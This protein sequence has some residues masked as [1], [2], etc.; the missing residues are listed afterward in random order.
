MCGLIKNY[1]IKSHFP[2]IPTFQ[3]KMKLSSIVLLATLPAT[4]HALAQPA[5]GRRAFL[6][7]AA[8]NTA[9]IT[10]AAVTSSPAFAADSYS[11]DTGDV[12][13]PKKEK[14]AKSGNGGAVVGGA[15]GASVALSLPFFLPNLMRLAGINNAKNPTKK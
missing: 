2:T 5:T 9:A 12:V 1:D 3:N 15:L 11:L 8:S 14:A 4:T 7:N 10:T 13:V 6:S